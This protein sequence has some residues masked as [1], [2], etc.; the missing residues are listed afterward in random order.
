MK[1][2]RKI[3]PGLVLLAAFLVFTLLICYVDVKPIGAAASNV[4]FASVNK[5]V[6]KLFGAHKTIYKLTEIL[7][8]LTWLVVAFFGLL[9]LSQLVH[10]KSLFK[11]DRDIILLGIGYAVM[12]VFY[13]LFD[14]LPFNYRP[15]Y[16]WDE[17]VLEA[18][19]PSS[20]TLMLVFVMATAVMQIARRVRSAGKRFAL[21]AVCVAV[22]AVVTVGRLACGVHWFTDIIGGILLAAALATLYY[23]LINAPEKE[24]AAPAEATE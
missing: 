4:G 11:V 19:Y 5:A 12:L 16:P 20:H 3:V 8:Y 13:V 7:G 1:S 17:G 15:K 24:P 14:K 23:E 9:G 2:I 22:A 10:R 21:T 6:N 18:S